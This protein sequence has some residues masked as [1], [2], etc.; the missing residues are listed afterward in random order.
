MFADLRGVRSCSRNGD[1]L[2]GLSGT[3]ESKLARYSTFRL[4][5]TLT[6]ERDSAQS[7]A[8]GKADWGE[9]HVAGSAESRSGGV[10]LG[11]NLIFHASFRSV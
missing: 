9:L 4:H 7:S 5:D 11:A 2:V 3:Q 1:T 10:E 8:C 6:P